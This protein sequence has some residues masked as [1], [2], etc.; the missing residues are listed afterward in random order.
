MCGEKMEKI[1][2]LQYFMCGMQFFRHYCLE[3]LV[4]SDKLSETSQGCLGLFPILLDNN[5]V[6]QQAVVSDSG[7]GNPRQLVEIHQAG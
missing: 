7:G 5:S 2:T 6:T 1:I 3:K 4:S